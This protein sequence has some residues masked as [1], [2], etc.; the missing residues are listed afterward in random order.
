MFEVLSSPFHVAR[1][2][3]FLSSVVSFGCGDDAFGF[4]RRQAVWL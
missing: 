1:L 3:G 4:W 2:L